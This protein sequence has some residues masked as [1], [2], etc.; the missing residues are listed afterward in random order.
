MKMKLFKEMS[1][2]ELLR[3]IDDLK[4]E[5]FELR[6]QAKAG[7]LE[8]SAKIR[9]ARRDLAKALTEQAIRAAKQA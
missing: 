2:E 7:Q 6:A 1:D 9:T 3:Q 4:K 8:S 5:K